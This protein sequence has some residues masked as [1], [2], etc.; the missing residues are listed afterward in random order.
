MNN[1]RYEIGCARLNVN[2]VCAVAI[3]KKLCLVDAINLMPVRPLLEVIVTPLD[4]LA[5]Q[6]PDHITCSP[7]VLFANNF[8]HLIGLFIKPERNSYL[9]FHLSS[10]S[11]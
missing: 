1:P 11:W 2:L 8:K 6:Y 3:G 7:L 10:I 5:D 9:L 4:F